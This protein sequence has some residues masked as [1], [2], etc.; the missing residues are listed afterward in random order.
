M[1]RELRFEAIFAYT[2]DS[3]K[4]ND[5]INEFRKF[6]AMVSDDNPDVTI[7]DEKV[8]DTPTKMLC[9]HCKGVISGAIFVKEATDDEEPIF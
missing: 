2:S 8:D 5:I 3:I 4:T 1:D 6:I 9:P 7:T